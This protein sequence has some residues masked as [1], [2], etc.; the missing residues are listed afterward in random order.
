MIYVKVCYTVCPVSLQVFLLYF[1]PSAADLGA[2]I[3]NLCSWVHPNPSSRQYKCKL[4]SANTLHDVNS[5]MSRATGLLS[6]KGCPK[7][8]K[9]CFS[10]TFIV[11]FCT[12]F[13]AAESDSW[14][15]EWWPHWGDAEAYRHIWR[16]ASS[17]KHRSW[18]CKRS[19]EL[20]VIFWISE[21]GI[22][23]FL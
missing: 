18:Y 9:V 8:W 3:Q 10:F 11:P 7:P 20:L 5:A 17:G 16:P 19:G 4:T 1:H 2:S 23:D 21:A 13:R 6:S 22:P 14:N 15:R 12:Y